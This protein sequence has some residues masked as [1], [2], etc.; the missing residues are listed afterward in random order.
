MIEITWEG[1]K[2]FGDLLDRAES[3]GIQ[4]LMKAVDGS[5][6]HCLSQAQKL[7]PKLTGD[8]EGSGNADPVKHIGHEI[9]KQIGFHTKYARRR[10]EE[11]YNLGTISRGKP[12]VDGMMVGRKYLEQPLTRYAPKYFKDWADALRKVFK[13]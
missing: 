2:E 10:H 1:I 7:A 4:V 12:G 5:G 3:E 9:V 8:L 11:V 13:D 6:E